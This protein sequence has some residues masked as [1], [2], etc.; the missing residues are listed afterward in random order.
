MCQN[1]LE[2]KR[3]KAL[4]FARN[5]PKPKVVQEDVVRKGYSSSDSEFMNG[6]GE[7]EPE[8]TMA[9]VHRKPANG[10]KSGKGFAQ[11]TA[12]EVYDSQYGN[13]NKLNEL[14]QKHL[15][16]R[17]QIDLIKKSMGMK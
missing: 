2:S 12:Q 8:L 3:E 16:G 9:A 11:L 1:K 7:N 14:E 10:K 4:N 15:D 5:V 6:L 17:K 13:T